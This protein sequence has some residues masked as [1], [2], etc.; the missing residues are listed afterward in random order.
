MSLSQNNKCPICERLIEQDQAF[1]QFDCKEK[2]K[3]HARCGFTIFKNA[4]STCF[5][6]ESKEYDLDA[7]NLDFGD[8]RKITTELFKTANNRIAEDDSNISL[9]SYWFKKV[10]D[11]GEKKITEMEGNIHLLL[12]QQIPFITLQQKQIDKYELLVDPIVTLDEWFKAGY[13]IDQLGNFKLTW[14]ELLLMGLRL[15]TIQTLPLDV[16]IEKFGA[17]IYEILDMCNYKFTTLA[18][19]KWSSKEFYALGATAPVLYNL[20]LKKEE[21]KLFN[22]TIKEWKKD[23]GMT[24]SLMRDFGIYKK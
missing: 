23:L 15:K 3:Y 6:C 17:T 16:L 12:K 2:H 22:F 19:F 4:N 1:I 11:F 14:D 7:F 5:K 9:T 8:D 18:K 13:T 20:D 21:F 10:F 24:E